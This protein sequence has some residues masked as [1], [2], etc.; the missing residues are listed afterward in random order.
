MCFHQDTGNVIVL[1]GN[2]LELYAG[3]TFRLLAA[4]TSDRGPCSL[5]TEQPHFAYL[6]QGSEVV[7]VDCGTGSVATRRKVAESTAASW[8]TKGN[9]FS[10]FGTF[11]PSGLNVDSLIIENLQTGAQT[12]LPET[13][14]VCLAADAGLAVLQD[15][16]CLLLYDLKTQQTQKRLPKP[17]GS[18][19]YFGKFIEKDTKIVLEGASFSGVYDVENGTWIADWSLKDAFLCDVQYDER[20]FCWIA[21]YLI[22][23]YENGQLRSQRVA[24][25]RH[26]KTYEPLARIGNFLALAPDGNAFVSDG[27]SAVLKVPLYDGRAVFAAM[28]AFLGESVLTPKQR[29]RYHLF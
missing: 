13:V 14:L 2:R 11:S 20:R 3:R 21:T 26:G 1:Y 9:R 6:I 25:V 4:Y 7:Q 24:L 5:D 29:E 28:E 19:V 18:H 12:A 8:D 27:V 16:D 17:A 10:Y 23:K 22:G 15:K